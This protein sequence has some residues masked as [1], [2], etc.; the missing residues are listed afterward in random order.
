MF[1][2]APTRRAAWSWR[3][4]IA[5]RF[6]GGSPRV[7]RRPVDAMCR[8]LRKCFAG[9]PYSCEQ[10]L[11]V[12]RPTVK[13]ATAA[14]VDKN[15]RS[16]RHVGKTERIILFLSFPLTAEFF[17]GGSRRTYRLL[18]LRS[19]PDQTKPLSRLTGHKNAQTWRCDVCRSAL[20]A[21]PSPWLNVLRIHFLLLHVADLPRISGILFG[22][23]KQHA[24]PSTAH[25]AGKERRRGAWRKD[26]Q[27]CCRV[28]PRRLC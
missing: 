1:R 5:T 3:K 6:C 21:P 8:V 24:C 12:Y 27:K 26:C 16:R 18:K 23:D 9:K 14:L 13:P 4:L 15:C 19:Q 7:Q 25:S 28:L 20:H 17:S 2:C 22:A 11:V 10:V